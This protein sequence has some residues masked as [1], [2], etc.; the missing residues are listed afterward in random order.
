HL[1]AAERDEETMR[2][3]SSYLDDASLHGVADACYGAAFLRRTG[4]LEAAIKF[5]HRAADSFRETKH[6]A[7]MSAICS[8]TDFRRLA[9][10]DV[11]SIS[12][13]IVFLSSPRVRPKFVM[14]A[15]GDETYYR[16]FQA[17]YRDTFFRHNRSSDCALHFHVFDPSDALLEEIENASAGEDR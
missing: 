6:A 8:P 2:I 1:A 16:P 9:D 5:F 7:P 17:I 11:S 13:P 12:N 15:T 4:N 10:L 3:A 14:C